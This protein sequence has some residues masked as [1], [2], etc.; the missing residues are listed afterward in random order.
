MNHWSFLTDSVALAAISV[1]IWTVYCMIRLKRDLAAIDR[2]RLAATD[3]MHK[4]VSTAMTG[5][6]GAI[7]SSAGPYRDALPTDKAARYTM[8]ERAIEDVHALFPVFDFPR[9]CAT[10]GSPVGKIE[11]VTQ[12]YLTEMGRAFVVV[13]ECHW[14][15]QWQPG[16]GDRR[17]SNWPCPTTR[18]LC[19]C[20]CGE[21]LYDKSMAPFAH[22]GCAI[23]IARDVHKV[24][25]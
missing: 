14:T 13:Y 10:C 4:N 1:G 24:A 7:G 6:T 16:L 21:R 8:I 9:T 12:K 2:Q 17:V 18:E 23:K 5:A 11:L 15:V 3:T 22:V 20:G 25:K 19:A